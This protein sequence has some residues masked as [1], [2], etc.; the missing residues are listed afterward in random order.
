[1]LTRRALLVATAAAALAAP[2]R[3]AAQ[4]VPG[5]LRGALDATH[6]GVRPG[7]VDDQS[8]ALSRALSKAAAEGRPLFLPPGRYAVADIDLPERAQLIGVPGES[9]LAYSGGNWLLRSRGAQ[10]LRLE[11]LVL[12]GRQRP[13]QADMPGLLSAEAVGEA[14]VENCTILDSAGSGLVLSGCAGRVARCHVS[15]VRLAGLSLHESRGLSATDN[16]IEDCGDR[17]I[18]VWR[19][20]PGEDGTLLRGNRISRI[21]ALSGGT[22]Q[23]GNGIHLS[24]ADGVIVADNRI[25]DCDF[26]AARAF[27]S[28][29]VRIAGNI[30][31]GSGET[32]LYVEFA[33]VGAIVTGNL[34]D[35]AATGISFANFPEYGGRLGVCSGNVVRNLA[36]YL[37]LPN[38]IEGPYGVG[39]TVEADIAVT[40]NVVEEAPH[41]GLRLG[42]G[43]YLR[44]VSATGNVIRRA[45]I[46]I[47]VTVVD[48]AGP[49]LI[50]DNLVS[51]SS[52]GAIL[53]MRWHEI[54]S[55]ELSGAGGD[56]FPHLTIAR[57]R[58]G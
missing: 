57:N 2:I 20:D 32:A 40:G 26:S 49:A 12:D 4:I 14:V 55:G 38:G 19:W 9:R 13:L 3:A 31:T 10:R 30:V 56:R 11:G 34:V 28:S 18:F 15:G 21:R 23:Y 42:W 50:A 43:P 5:D 8:V 7:A 16:V 25:D 46:G 47:A 24:K 41:C 39:I 51:E 17:G 6:E 53:G 58:V 36:S 22:G 1:M 45:G 52:R 35:G 48:G 29:S 54:A 33:Y 27:S 37:R 44:D